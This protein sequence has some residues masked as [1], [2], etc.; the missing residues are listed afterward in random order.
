MY[1]RPGASLASVWPLVPFWPGWSHAGRGFA[2]GRSVRKLH[3]AR[4]SELHSASRGGKNSVT[5]EGRNL[6]INEGKHRP[7]VTKC[8]KVTLLQVPRV[9]PHFPHN[10]SGIPA[11]PPH[12]AEIAQK[13]RKSIRRC[14][15]AALPAPLCGLPVILHPLPPLHRRLAPFWPPFG[16]P[17]PFWASLV[18]GPIHAGN[19]DGEC[20]SAVSANSINSY[21]KFL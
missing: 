2:A 17:V 14:D 9:T 8:K 21:G 10:L 15:A 6:L 20:V 4:R 5:F 16:L 13:S 19:T 12:G 3:S 18:S 11:T 7:S 1:S